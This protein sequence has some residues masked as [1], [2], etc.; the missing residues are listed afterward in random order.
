MARTTNKTLTIFRHFAPSFPEYYRTGLVKEYRSIIR[1]WVRGLF[2]PNDVEP[3]AGT[4]DY[5]TSVILLGPDIHVLCSPVNWF[6]F[7]VFPV[8]LIY[9]P[10][11]QTCGRFTCCMLWPRTDIGCPLVSKSCTTIPSTSTPS[12]SVRAQPSSNSRHPL[13]SGTASTF[14]R[15]SPSLPRSKWAEIQLN[16]TSVYSRCCQWEP[17]T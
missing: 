6:Q 14:L 17:W 3:N 4:I 15:N 12:G 16:G 11:L 5:C 13:S 2:N 7:R 8:S 1:V 10:N 9:F